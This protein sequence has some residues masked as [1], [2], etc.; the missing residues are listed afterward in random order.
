MEC[1]R[2]QTPFELKHPSQK[3]CSTRCGNAAYTKHWQSTVAL[4][5]KKDMVAF[6]GGE[7]KNCGYK[8][9]LAGLAFHHLDPKKKDFGM[10][11]R[12]FSNTSLEKLKDELAKCILLCHCCHAEEHYPHLAITGS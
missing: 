6:L 8:K 1:V 10:D 5:R 2:C 12:S 4:Q 7:C 11:M 3:Y 9:N